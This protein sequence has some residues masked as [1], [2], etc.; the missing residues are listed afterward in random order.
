LA[1]KIHRAEVRLLY[2]GLREH[3]QKLR[4]EHSV[5]VVRMAE[6]NR[7]LAGWMNQQQQ[8]AMLR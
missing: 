1:P 4:G 2:T 6:Q 8:F 7:D 3:G 5:L